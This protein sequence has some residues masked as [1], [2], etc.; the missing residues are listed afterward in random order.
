M[1]LVLSGGTIFKEGDDRTGIVT[2]TATITVPEVQER[3]TVIYIHQLRRLAEAS[4][5]KD[6]STSVLRDR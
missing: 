4:A 5:P 6:E 2:P 1:R 3:S